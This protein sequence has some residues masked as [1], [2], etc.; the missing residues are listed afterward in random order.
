MKPKPS[1]LCSVILSLGLAEAA[2]AESSER[3]RPADS[4][5]DSIGVNSHF[6]WSQTRYF[7]RFEEVKAKLLESGVRHIRGE[8]L[9]ETPASLPAIRHFE[10]LAASGNSGYHPGSETPP[11]R[12][13]P[14]PHCRG[15]T[16]KPVVKAGYCER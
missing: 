16:R 13:V 9:G 10:S 8:A 12:L 15:L 7:T 5:V 1:H 4:F 2:L 6:H 14:V 11:G 3:A